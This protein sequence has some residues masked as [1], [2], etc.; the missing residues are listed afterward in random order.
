MVTTTASRDFF[1]EQAKD[2]AFDHRLYAALARREEDPGT[3]RL[4]EDFSS[5][6]RHHLEFW[7]R[8]SNVEPDSIPVSSMRLKATMLASRVLGTAFTIRRLERLEKETIAE[9]E[10]ILASGDLPESDADELR[11][12]IA[13][14]RAHE[15]NMAERVA[16]PR[17]AYLG[18]AVLGLNDA[19]VELTGG[20]TGLVSSIKDTALIGFTALVIGLAASLSMA[21]SNFLSEGMSKDEDVQ[22]GKAAAYTGIAYVL[23]VLAL[24]APFFIATNRV[25]ALAATWVLA[26]GVIAA[27]SYY[28]AVVQDVSFRRRFFQ[29]LGLG[30]GVAV[31]T[32]GIGRALSAWIG[33]DV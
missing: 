11:A 33:I 2:E 6:E 30:L 7:A 9:Y 22:P 17:V 16:D 32:F 26:V 20:L 13:D 14:E 1:L 31:I 24:V 12:I 3:Q 29:M 18:A 15:K 19:L 21:A 27:F 10:V 23:V 5:Q 25:V 8:L 4:L 28:A